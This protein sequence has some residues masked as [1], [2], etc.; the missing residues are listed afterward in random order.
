LD[1]VAGNA[2]GMSIFVDDE[3]LIGRHA[4]GPGRLADDEEISRLHARLTRDTSGF[5]AI[6]DLGSTNG[7]FVNGLRI[8]VPKTLSE[9]D[10]IEIGATTLVVADLVR[11]ATEPATSRHD[12]EP[13]GR[14]GVGPRSLATA[15]DADDSATPAV[16]RAETGA[17]VTPP[18]PTLSLRLEIDF[19]AGEARLSLDDNSEPVRVTFDSDA[20]HADHRGRAG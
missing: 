7:T 20:W 9:G 6:E 1:V 17:D 16:A 13:M 19:A 11:A 18:P 5:C 2:L 4:E 15:A 14:A 3:L 12:H 10:I 8:S